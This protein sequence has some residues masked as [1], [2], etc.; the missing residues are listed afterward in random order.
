MP[1]ICD[2]WTASPTASGNVK[3]TAWS[4]TMPESHAKIP[5]VNPMGPSRGTDGK[6]YYGVSFLVAKGAE[7]F[8]LAS[9]GDTWIVNVIVQTWN[10]KANKFVVKKGDE[11]VYMPVSN[12]KTNKKHQTFAVGTLRQTA[13]LFRHLNAG[14]TLSDPAAFQGLAPKEPP[15]VVAPAPVA[16]PRTDGVGMDEFGDLFVD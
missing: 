12:I 8:P 6:T 16:E 15:P 2:N 13:E 1:F 10:S 11:D 9:G 14:T 3:V 7:K 5:G 4:T